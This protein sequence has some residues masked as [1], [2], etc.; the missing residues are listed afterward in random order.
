VLIPKK[1]QTPEHFPRRSGV[2]CFCVGQGGRELESNS[3]SFFWNKGNLQDHIHSLCQS[4]QQVDAGISCSFFQFADLRLAN[5]STL[6]D[7]EN[8]DII[9]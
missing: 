7:T 5:N 3:G 1:E 8:H 9:Q 6:F 4:L 2:F